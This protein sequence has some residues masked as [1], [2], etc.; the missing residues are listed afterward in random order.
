MQTK[1][2]TSCQIEKNIE[3]FHQHKRLKCGRVGRCKNCVKRINK[4]RYH[5]DPRIRQK[6]T[7]ARQKR[8]AWIKE[9]K[10]SRGCC[11]CG[12]KI[13]AILDFHH[14][15]QKDFNISEN[16]GK[17]FKIFLSEIEK[18]VV[19]CANHHRMHHAG[20]IDVNQYQQ[21]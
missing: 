19:V 20:L 18:C 13:G 1:T 8:L 2:C 7:R 21:C 3:D 17:A 11:V 10:E 6:A 14:I 15:N 9:Y 4:D 12:T 5:K 16:Y